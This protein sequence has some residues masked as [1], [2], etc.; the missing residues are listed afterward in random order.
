MTLARF[1]QYNSYG[2]ILTKHLNHFTM[3]DFQKILA[4]ALTGAAVGLVAGI[5]LAPDKGSATRKRIAD[6]ASQL[7]DKAKELANS[8]NDTILGFRQ[9]V[10]KKKDEVLHNEEASLR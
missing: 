5:L 3:T 6:G 8:A 10:A 1:F 7:S 9:K 2:N 4:A